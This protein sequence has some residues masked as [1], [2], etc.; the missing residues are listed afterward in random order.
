VVRISHQ[1]EEIQT[2]LN[3]WVTNKPR[4]FFADGIRKLPGRWQ[5]CI[6]NNGDYFEH[7]ATTDN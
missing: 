2:V 3:N 7:V 6:L 5:K 4:T 1:R